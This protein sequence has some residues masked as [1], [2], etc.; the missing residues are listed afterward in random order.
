MTCALSDM[1]SS[2]LYN[3]WSVLIKQLSCYIIILGLISAYDT[4]PHNR[5]QSCS[6]KV[7]MLHKLK[8]LSCDIVSLA[9]HCFIILDFG[10]GERTYVIRSC[11]LCETYEID[12]G[13][14]ILK[15]FINYL[16]FTL[17][18]QLP[19]DFLVVIQNCDIHSCRIG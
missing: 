18:N 17:F 2:D 12:I 13:N 10:Q 19:I 16:L 9:M 8:V 6:L 7:A 11:L 4:L 3:A 5:S 1:K 14:F 15:A